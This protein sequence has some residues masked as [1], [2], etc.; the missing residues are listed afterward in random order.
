MRASIRRLEVFANPAQGARRI[1]PYVVILQT[2]LSAEGDYRLVAPL[3]PA[4]GPP[5]PVTPAVQ[6]A[7]RAL[8]VLMPRITPLRIAH[9]QAGVGSLDD[10]QDEIGRALDWIFFGV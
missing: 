10:W 5:T 6:V 3:V 1:F 4:R 9:L 2:E 7:G 8:L